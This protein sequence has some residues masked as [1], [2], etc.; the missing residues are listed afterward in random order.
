MV[1]S[2]VSTTPDHPD[3]EDPMTIA[4]AVATLQGMVLMVVI[5]AIA[6]IRML[7]ADLITLEMGHLTI[8]V[9]PV[10]QTAMEI[11]MMTADM[12]EA[13]VVPWEDQQVASTTVDAV[14]VVTVMV[15]L[16]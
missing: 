12:E 13:E 9:T 16:V 2:F 4:A 11:T 1:D 7:V 15:D 5:L 10:M 8:L 14:A 6:M 3:Q